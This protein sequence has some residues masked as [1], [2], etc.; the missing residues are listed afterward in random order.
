MPIDRQTI[1]ELIRD[2]EKLR[3]RPT[4]REAERVSGL[5]EA[6]GLLDAAVRL[7][8]RSRP[9]TCERDKH[10][11]A[12]LEAMLGRVNEARKAEKRARGAKVGVPS[13][14]RDILRRGDLDDPEKIEAAIARL[15]GQP[16]EARTWLWV[17]RETREQ[18]AKGLGYVIEDTIGD[19]RDLDARLRRDGIAAPTGGAVGAAEEAATGGAREAREARTSLVLYLASRE[20]HYCGTIEVRCA[21]SEARFAALDQLAGAWPEPAS[22]A[23]DGGGKRSHEV[24]LRELREALRREHAQLPDALLRAE[25]RGSGAGRVALVVA[26]VRRLKQ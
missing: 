9:A 24:A 2:V 5:L 7:L 20:I 26:E 1:D 6:H 14:G 17:E 11:R 19:L 13:G 10:T 18:W 4:S 8:A 21:L 16:P 12:E 25:P 15:E 23:L 22:L 3:A